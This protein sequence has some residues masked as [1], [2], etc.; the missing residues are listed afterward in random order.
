[1][2]CK[3]DR[4]GQSALEY[5]V[6]LTIIV[7]A[8]IVMQVYIKRGIQ[9]RFKESADDI[10]EQFDPGHQVYESYVKSNSTVH[11]TVDRD[12][13]TRQALEDRHGNEVNQTTLRWGRTSTHGLSDTT[14][15]W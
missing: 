9:G 13:T 11:E 6:L 4:R 3:L 8:I 2:F 14:W 12:G 5:G 10:G 1:M 15:H 7:A